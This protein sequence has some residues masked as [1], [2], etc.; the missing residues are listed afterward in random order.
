MRSLQSTLSLKFPITSGDPYAASNP[1]DI[2][3]LVSLISLLSLATTEAGDLKSSLT[4]SLSSPSDSITT[5]SIS[6]DYLPHLVSSHLTPLTIIQSIIP[7]FKTA[8]KK[9]VPSPNVIVA[10]R[11]GVDSI[12]WPSTAMSNSATATSCEVLRRE[13]AANPEVS[14]TR[15]VIID[16]GEL[17][18]KSKHSHHRSPRRPTDPKVFSNAVLRIVG[19]RRSPQP[20]LFLASFLGL[21]DWWRGDRFSVGAG[22]P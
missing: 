7:L 2:P 5:L 9:G 17:A 6:K 4:A 15:V 20:G 8:K 18:V 21:R 14:G 1:T 3:V 22:G 13:T 10:L 12:R 19:D 16:V 11:G